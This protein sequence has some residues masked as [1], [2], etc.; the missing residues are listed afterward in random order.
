MEEPPARSAR[1]TMLRLPPMNG[2]AR[3]RRPPHPR[4]GTLQLPHLQECE[5]MTGRKDSTPPSGGTKDQENRTREKGADE[6]TP[7]QQSKGRDEK[8]PGSDSNR[9]RDD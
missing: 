9:E 5:A 3:R 2:K 6:R 8:R 1:R 4:A 7:G